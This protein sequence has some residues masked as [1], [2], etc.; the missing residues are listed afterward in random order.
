[1]RILRSKRLWIALA[2]GYTIVSLRYMQSRLPAPAAPPLPAV[3]HVAN[4]PS[5][6]D[7][8]P[9]G[10]RVTDNGRLLTFT[11]PDLLSFCCDFRFVI[12]SVE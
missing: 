11:V 4:V 3:H 1:M 8:V 2:V 9:E 12:R 7:Q 6:L 5:A 10:P